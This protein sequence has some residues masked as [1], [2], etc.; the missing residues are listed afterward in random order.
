MKA[1]GLNQYGGPGVL[2]IV[3][4]ED[5][6]PGAGEVRVAV[7]AAG[8][9]PV[10]QMVREGSLA[11]FYE[12]IQPPFVPGMDIAGMIDE[13]GDEVDPGLGLR[14]GM[15]VT[16]VVSNFG[17]YGGYSQLVCLPAVSVAAAPVGASFPEAASFLM[18]A[19]TARN[20]L[21][22]LA[23]PKGSELL[24]TGAA[25]AVGT[26]ACILAIRDGLNVAAIAA[27]ADEAMLRSLGVAHFIPRGEDAAEQVRRAVAGGVD[28]V[29][30]AAGIREEIFPALRDG[31]RFITLRFWDDA[32][33]IRGIAV[34][35]VNVRD[36]VTDHD[37]IVNLVRLAAEGTLPMR[38][39]AVIPARDAASA[40]EQLEKGGLRG[41]VVLDFTEIDDPAAT[42]PVDELRRIADNDDFHIS[43]LRENGTTYGT[44]TWIWSVRVDDGI[45]VRAYNGRSSRWYQA[46]MKQKRGRISTAGMTK[47]VGFE[48][49]D[50]PIQERIDDAYRTK[51]AGSPYLGSM[52]GER[53]RAATVRVSPYE[54]KV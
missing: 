23:L 24:V 51:Y 12:G 7:K 3:D 4:L 43:P 49:V 35:F 6:H 32:P 26:Y 21:D 30:D 44:P 10:D 16:G 14:K 42:W 11:T 19:L 31:G 40:H 25:G 34:K 48:P 29:V 52:I 9:N 15:A 38:V 33:D 54:S 50:G 1:I 18:N 8:V 20:A 39:A 46:A 28:A 47:D 41:R 53:A 37:A 2:E 22:E 17:G 45:Y 36:R 13:I 5:P 27:P